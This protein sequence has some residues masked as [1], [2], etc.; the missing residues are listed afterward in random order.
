MCRPASSLALTPS[1]L[2]RIRELLRQHEDWARSPDSLDGA[3]AEE[4]LDFVT[5]ELDTL[6]EAGVTWNGSDAPM[7]SLYYEWGYLINVDTATFEVYCGFQKAPH[8]AGRFAHRS[9]ARDGYYPVA[10]VAAWPLADLPDRAEF[11]AQ[12]GAY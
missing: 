2:E 1:D 6:L 8:T 9:P 4:L 5:W 3:S 10:L 7:D 11:L 12:L